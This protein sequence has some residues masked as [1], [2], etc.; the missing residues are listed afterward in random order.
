MFPNAAHDDMADAMT[1]ASAWLLQLPI[2]LI[3]CPSDYSVL[4]VAG[5]MH[6]LHMNLP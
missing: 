6:T 2:R 1:Q 4:G 5:N 3:G